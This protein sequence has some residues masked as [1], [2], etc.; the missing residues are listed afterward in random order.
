MATKKTFPSVEQLTAPKG[1]KHAQTLDLAASVAEAVAEAVASATGEWGQVLDLTYAVESRVT[2]AFQSVLDEIVRLNIARTRATVETLTGLIT[3]DEA[4]QPLTHS[5]NKRV[6]R[7]WKRVQATWSRNFARAF[8]HQKEF[9]LFLTEQTEMALPWEVEDEKRKAAEREATKS[10][11]LVVDLKAGLLKATLPSIGKPDELRALV[12]YTI[13][14]CKAG[15]KLALADHIQ[16]GL[17]TLFG[18]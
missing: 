15:G 4:F 18:K 8:Y 10:K 16:E 11:D 5:Q 14:S 1:G 6:A 12:E 7:D 3:E 2:A 9:S 17:N 13:R